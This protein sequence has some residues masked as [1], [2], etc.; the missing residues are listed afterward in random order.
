VVNVPVHKH[1]G[2]AVQ[3]FVMAI[4][5]VGLYIATGLGKFGHKDKE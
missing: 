4:V 2:Y 1:T 5:L 3:W